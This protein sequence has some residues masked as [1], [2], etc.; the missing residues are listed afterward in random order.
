MDSEAVPVIYCVR[1]TDPQ[2]PTAVVS[3]YSFKPFENLVDKPIPDGGS[4]KPYAIMDALY[5]VIG[6]WPGEPRKNQL[7]DSFYLPGHDNEEPFV[8]GRD[9]T[10]RTYTRPTIRLHSPLVNDLL[11]KLVHYYPGYDLEGTQIMHNHPYRIL[12]HYYDELCQIRDV[13]DEEDLYKKI[14]IQGYDDEFECSKQMSA[15]LS[16]IISFVDDH[17]YKETAVKE[18]E[19]HRNGRATFDNLWLL[20]KP[21]EIVFANVRGEVAGFIVWRVSFKTQNSDSKSPEDKW[22]VYLWN[23]GYTGVKLTRQ[24]S[25]YSIDR[26]QGE[27]DISTL[28]VF[29]T[30]YLKDGRASPENLIKRGKRYYDI[31]C[32]LPAYRKYD[33]PVIDEPPQNVCSRTHYDNVAVD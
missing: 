30:K 23:L 31:M 28:D 27:K 14:K 2:K 10:T 25:T 9:F 12:S 7:R 5:T 11:R 17:Y 15:H 8:F 21:G 16:Q 13:Y 18:I 26:F 6:T 1:I 4:R 20:F 29:P 32:S 3:R 22:I 24:A 33:G 19:L